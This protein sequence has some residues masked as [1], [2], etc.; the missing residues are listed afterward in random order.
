MELASQERLAK[1][2]ADSQERIADI[3]A[4]ARAQE[5]A[6]ASYQASLAADRTTY[7]DP[8][9][10]SRSRVATWLMA[11]VDFV[12]GMIRPGSTANWWVWC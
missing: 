6:E 11:A 10:Q 12:R 7:L 5:A 1:L 4:Q 8:A 3:Q 9:A 2:T